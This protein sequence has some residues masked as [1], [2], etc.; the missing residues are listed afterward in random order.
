MQF[1]TGVNITTFQQ[2]YHNQLVVTPNEMVG[3]T[4]LGPVVQTLVSANPGLNFKPGF[5]F[6]LSKVL[7]RIIFSLLFRVSNYQIVGKEN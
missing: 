5:F 7:S 3:L 2:N 6:F 4:V 1:G